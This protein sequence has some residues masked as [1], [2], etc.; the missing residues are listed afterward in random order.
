MKDYSH[1]S[2]INHGAPLKNFKTCSPVAVE[3]RLDYMSIHDFEHPLDAV[4]VFGPE[5]GDISKALLPL[6][7]HFVQIPTEYCLNLAQ[8]V[9]IVLY[10]R[11]LKQGG[12]R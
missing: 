6:C 4:Y 12:R 7:H 5:D 9:N 3:F 10:D 2:L 8:A 1:V 11:S